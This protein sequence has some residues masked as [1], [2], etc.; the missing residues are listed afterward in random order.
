MLSKQAEQLERREVLE[1]DLRE[2]CS[3]FSQFAQS[4]AAEARGRFTAH[5]K[6]TVIGSTPTPA[7]AY[8]AAFLQHDPVPDEPA[9]GVDVNALEPTGEPHELKARPAPLE[10]SCLPSPAQALPS[11]SQAPPL[12]NER[13]G[14]F[15]FRTYRRA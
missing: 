10:P 3:S 9:L 5:E 15:S 2:Q 12:A 13:L 11:R 8:P 1:N 6:S 7:S 14:S 4:E